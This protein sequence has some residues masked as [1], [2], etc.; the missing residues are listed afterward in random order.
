[1]AGIPPLH[2]GAPGSLL[3]QQQ[4]GVAQGDPWQG[5]RKRAETSGGDASRGGLHTHRTF[6]LFQS[7]LMQVWFAQRIEEGEK[8]D[9]CLT[10]V[11][12]SP[13]WDLADMDFASTEELVKIFPHHEA[14]IKEMGK[15]G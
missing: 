3:D 7:C 11:T 10:G 9:F 4:G 12:V 6:E 5:P 13:G 15:Q 14:I 2:G 1:M 8:G